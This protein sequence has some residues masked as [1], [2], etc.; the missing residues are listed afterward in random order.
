MLFS[1]HLYP[2]IPTSSNRKVKVTNLSSNTCKACIKWV[3]QKNTLTIAMKCCIKYLHV[4]RHDAT[5]R[6]MGHHYTRS[7]AEMPL[8]YLKFLGRTLTMSVLFWA[9]WRILLC[10]YIQSMQDIDILYSFQ[11]IISNLKDGY[12]F[13]QCAERE[14]RVFFHF[15]ELI[16]SAKERRTQD[17]VEFTVVPVSLANVV[18]VPLISLRLC[19]L[20]SLAAHRDHFVQ[21][22]SV[23]PSVCV[24][25]CLSGSNTFLVVTH[26]YVSQATHAFLGMLALCFHIAEWIM[27]CCGS[28]LVSVSPC[29]SLKC[30]EMIETTLFSL[31][32]HLQSI[33][34]YRD[35]FVWR[36]SVFVCLLVTLS[37]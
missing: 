14:N 25:V 4:A 17:D 29:I 9:C 26:S 20:W 11:G 1:F 10:L 30:C 12:G 13:I 2:C 8:C 15:S 24:C 3:M 6:D 19:R 16:D 31:L 32:C 28:V 36:L 37:W 33:A 18:N 22:L 34:A 23:C 35:Y 21:R 5:R 7:H 27:S